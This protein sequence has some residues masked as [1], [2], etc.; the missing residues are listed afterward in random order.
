MYLDTCFAQCHVTGCKHFL[1]LFLMN[2]AVE[3]PTWLEIVFIFCVAFFSISFFVVTVSWLL[4][5]GF[6]YLSITKDIPDMLAFSGVITT[7]VI[8]WKW[9][10][11]KR[12]AR[13]LL[14]GGLFCEACSDF[15]VI[16]LNIYS[17]AYPESGAVNWF[18]L[19]A[20]FGTAAYLLMSFGLIA[21]A[22]TILNPL[23]Q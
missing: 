22:R 17:A 8:V 16:F 20:I 9:V 6:Y 19:V 11:K 21:L 12:A 1:I 3:Y 2:V 15:L 4:S 18:L 7:L 10:Q 14:A 13:N 5:E 23:Q